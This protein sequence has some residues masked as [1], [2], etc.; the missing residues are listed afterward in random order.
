MRPRTLNRPDLI[1]ILALALLPWLFFWPLVAPNPADRLSIKQ[2]DFTEQYFPL[3]AFTA[4]EWVEGRLPLWNPSLFGGQPALADI[5][6]GALYPPHVLEALLAGWAGWGFPLRAQE[7]QVIL[8]FSWAAVGA[9]LLGR[10]LASR[11]QP[12]RGPDPLRP[13]RLA[14]VVASVT[15]TYGGYLTGFPVQ[16]L[17]ILEVS[18]WL[19]WVIWLLSRTLERA[20]AGGRGREALAAAAWT[21]VAFALSILAGHPQTTLYLFYL[22]LA[23]S[24]YRAGAAWRAA[25]PAQGLRSGLAVLGHSALVILLG[26]ALA[27]AQLL[28]TLEFIRHSLRA[29]LDYQ[30]VSAGLPLNELAA[31]LYPGFFGGSPQYVGIVSLVL[32]GVALAVG[33]PR[34][35]TWFWAAAG[36]AAL[37]LALG[38]R[39]F[40]Y[41]LFYLLAPGF[42]AVRQQ[43][44]VFLVFSLAA[45]LLAGQGALALARPLPRRESRTWRRFQ[46]GLRRVA[47]AAL[48]VTG[49]YVYGST[50]AQVRGDEVNLMFG[51]LRHHLL[52]LIV[53]AGALGLLAL[54][55]RRRFWRQ[56]GL[57]LLAGWSAFNLFTVNWRFNL[58]TPPGGGVYTPDGVVQFLQGETAGQ[59]EPVRIASAGLLPGGNNAASVY[60]LLDVTG[61]TPLQLAD[62]AAFAEQLPAWRYWQLLGIRY[63]LDTRS[64]DGEGLRRVFEAGEVKVYAVTDPFPFA[65]LVYETEVVADAAAAR[66]RL[67]ADAFDLARRA[68][69]ARPLSAGPALSPPGDEGSG[70]VRVVDFQPA[71]LTI[72]VETPSPG[73]LVV[74]QVNYPGW[75]AQVDGQ[76]A[77]IVPVDVILQGVVVEAGAHTVRLKFRPASF[78][79]GAILTGLGGLV[80]LALIANRWFMVTR[81]RGKIRVVWI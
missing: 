71:A 79:W 39:S 37:L 66:S 6:S 75:Q 80:A 73:L 69:V 33:R 46:R 45:A 9:Y 28:P 20:V 8:H 31:V 81:E 77:E 72:E 10:H 36:V 55:P 68:I 65:R 22:V 1:I 59:G 43:E 49:L 16:Q 70:R 13:A 24:L 63:V 67:G 61:N 48:A 44:R 35:A 5:Q 57:L 14:G 12:G 47:L 42:D 53:L 19:P 74:S 25:A 23:Y 76:P 7:L 27:A 51:V 29:D 64:L 15:F 78:H 4:R 52:G 58:E 17:T 32:I 3:R 2:G 60:G 62:S 50:A 40:L 56:W 54:R 38:G 11:W 26:L 30:A 34:R 18:A 41:P 21:A